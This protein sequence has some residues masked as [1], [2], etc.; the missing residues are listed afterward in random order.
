MNK[1]VVVFAGVAVLLGSTWLDAQ[2]NVSEERLA[3]LIAELD[4]KQFETRRQAHEALLKIG[5]P[6]VEPLK[7]ARAANPSLEV[8][9]RIKAI[10]RKLAVRADAGPAVGD[11]QVRLVADRKSIKLG[12]PVE[13]TVTLYNLSDEDQNVGIGYS[14]HGNDFA[15]GWAFR[16]LVAGPDSEDAEIPCKCLAWTCDTGAEPLFVTVP[17][18]GHV[19]YIVSAQVMNLREYGLS[20]FFFGDDTRGYYLLGAQTGRR[21]RIQ[22]HLDSGAYRFTSARDEIRS[23]DAANAKARLWCGTIHS[24]EVHIQIQHDYLGEFVAPLSLLQMR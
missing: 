18:E 23:S 2:P 9:L 1:P 24:N 20:G 21:H 14:H 12:E 16:R 17:A 3:R 5:K 10:L 15:C 7:K 13:F 4:S 6:A 19:E 22:V 8:L 11:L